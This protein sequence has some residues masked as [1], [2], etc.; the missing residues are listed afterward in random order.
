M[1]TY[2]K[3]FTSGVE[4]FAIGKFKLTKSSNTILETAI[5]II[6]KLRH[7]YEQIVEDSRALCMK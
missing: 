7:Q 1:G 4:E 3:I 2:F 5:L 6:E